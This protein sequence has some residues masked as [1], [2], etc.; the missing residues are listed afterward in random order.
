MVERVPGTD[1]PIELAMVLL[2]LQRILVNDYLMTNGELAL[3]AISHGVQV[4]VETTADTV[5]VAL[6]QT[7]P[8]LRTLLQ[9]YETARDVFEGLA[10][11]FVREHLYRHI[12]DYIPSSTR[13]GRD[14][15]LKRLRQNKELFRYEE[16]DLG[17]MEAV[18]AGYLSGQTTLG[19]VLRSAAGYRTSGQ[20]QRVASAQIGAV[21]NEI[22][23]I[24]QDDDS[25]DLELDGSEPLPPITRTEVATDK[26][27]LLVG[28]DY[29]KLNNFRLFLSLSERL[30]HLEGD[31][32][33]QPHTT[34]IIWGAHRVIY[35]FSDPTA[36]LSLYYDIELLEPL[37]TP[38]TGGRMV[39]TTTIVTDTKMVCACPSR[40]HPSV[41]DRGGREVVLRAV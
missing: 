26:K 20:R 2:H 24:V 17:N 7:N 6:N 40:T 32:L 5:R 25:I 35:V 29:S 28:A 8:S 11:D 33:R 14:T 31:F 23:D 38:D 1:L 13:Q 4:Y 30:Y 16:R 18:L 22:P 39:P 34:R 36:S 27:V 19:E 15:L 10:K 37:D 9:S 41:C 21:E 12:R 3:A